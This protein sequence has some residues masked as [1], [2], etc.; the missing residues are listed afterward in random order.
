MIIGG[1][2]ARV[3]LARALYS[4]ETRLMLMD[5]KFARPNLSGLSRHL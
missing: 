4:K 3:S 1:Q 5:G 2:K